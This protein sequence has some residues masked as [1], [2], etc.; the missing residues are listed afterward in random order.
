VQLSPGTNA[1]GF[2]TLT[3]HLVYAAFDE[4]VTSKDNLY[5]TLQFFEKAP[6]LLAEATKGLVFL[7]LHVITK[8]S[9]QRGG[10]SRGKR[11]ACEKIF[12]GQRL[13]R[14]VNVLLAAFS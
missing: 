7:P 14:M 1:G 5:R 13:L 3:G 6:Q 11:G 8:Y 4:R 9:I 10:K 2:T 12:S